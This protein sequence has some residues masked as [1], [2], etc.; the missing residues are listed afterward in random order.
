MRVAEGIISEEQAQSYGWLE[1]P[2]KTNKFLER[3]NES[4][5]DGETF[6]C[7]LNEELPKFLKGANLADAN[8]TDANLADANLTD[9]NLRDANLADANLT[10][11]DL[12]GVK[13]DA[14]SILE[15]IDLLHGVDFTNTRLFDDGGLL[16]IEPSRKIII[17]RMVQL[18]ITD[19]KGLGAGYQAALKDAGLLDEAQ[20]ETVSENKTKAELEPPSLAKRGF[21]IVA[22]MPNE[23]QMENISKDPNVGYP[24]DADE[25]NSS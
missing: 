25:Y 18:G 2:Y 21:V 20:K 8:L 19:A 11:A 3:Y 4:Q 12:T 17:D 9:A 22:G 14:C 6:G 23:M 13:I 1:E 7:F 24:L 10:G 16:E 5:K 15:E